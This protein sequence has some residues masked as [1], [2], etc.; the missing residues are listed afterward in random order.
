MK[1]IKVVKMLTSA[2][3]IL[4]TSVLITSCANSNGKS[5]VSY[6]MS[7]GYGYP[8]YYGASPYYR[9]NVMVVR[10][11]A[12]AVYYNKGVRRR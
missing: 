7:V 10:P 8:M 9:S 5:S 3:L 2:V 4:A 12:R 1:I 6:S 11:P